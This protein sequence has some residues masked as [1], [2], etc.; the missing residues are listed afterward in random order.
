MGKVWWPVV[1]SKDASH[2]YVVA[3]G[4]LYL[5][6]DAGRSWQRIWSGSIGWEI[7]VLYTS[8]ARYLFICNQWNAYYST[9]DGVSWQPLNPPSGLYVPSISCVLATSIDDQHVTVFAGNDQAVVR[10]TDMGQTWQTVSKDAGGAGFGANY[11]YGSAS[12][13]RFVLAL[14]RASLSGSTWP[15]NMY[16]SFDTGSTWQKCNMTT[17]L[18]GSSNPTVMTPCR[19]VVHPTDPH[20]LYLTTRERVFGS[21]DCGDTWQELMNG[22]RPGDN[23]QG[24]VLDVADHRSLWLTK[25]DGLFASSDAGAS[26][27]KRD[28]SCTQHNGSTPW[29]LTPV[30]LN[31]LVQSSS[32]PDTWYYSSGTSFYVSKDHCATWS[33]VLEGDVSALWGHQWSVD[34]TRL[35]AEGP[36]GIS[37]STDGARSWSVLC[38]YSGTVCAVARS[39]AAPESLFATATTNKLLVSTDGGQSWSLFDTPAQFGIIIADPRNASTLYASDFIQSYIDTSDASGKTYKSVDAGR[40]WIQVFGGL[41]A[42][43]CMAMAVAPSDS[44]RVLWASRREVY[45]SKDAGLTWKLVLQLKQ[46]GITWTVAFSPSITNTMYVSTE[47]EGVLRTTDGGVTWAPA[48]AGM[49]VTKYWHLL[50]VESTSPYRLFVSTA[51]GVFESDD[52]A[53]SWIPVNSNAVGVSFKQLSCSPGFGGLP[54]GITTTG[55]WMQLKLRLQPPADVK[56]Q[57]QKNAVQLTWT[58][59]TAG[60]VVP[61]AYDIWR[62]TD[63]A[64]GS[65]VRIGR[66]PE[67]TTTYTDATTWGYK[68][69]YYKVGAWDG[70]ETP[71]QVLLSTAVN[72]ASLDDIP[73]VITLKSPTTN[74]WT[75][76]DASCSLSFSVTDIET[77]VASVTVDGSATGLS[78]YYGTYT[79][80]L[81]LEPG[82][83][84][85][86]IVAHDTAGNTTQL[87]VRI[88]YIRT[89]VAQVHPA[90][91]YV[92]AYISPGYRPVSV[93]TVR[94]RTFVPVRDLA[95][96][97]GA[98]VSWDA[99]ARRATITRGTTTVVLWIGKPTAMVN[100][101]RTPIDA[102]DSKVVPF[103][104]GGKT[105]MPVNFVASSFGATVSYDAKTKIVTITLKEG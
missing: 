7:Q 91:P 31:A 63:A 76:L 24:F 40:T 21:S 86:L 37:V 46:P 12:D 74:P 59:V 16:R 48:T 45:L 72:A 90:V 69:Y 50:A 9:D 100:D 85:V 38:D 4:G 62:S 3:D 10:S 27:I 83:R 11:L 104:E 73:P 54:M 92:S 67:G 56:A 35:C 28:V 34:G 95:E 84:Q 33:R 101:V 53:D 57:S 29:T 30:I 70:Q 82:W 98:Q 15:R 88:R 47:T 99:V 103:I 71:E 66:A 79:Q 55:I 81:T 49:S 58:S 51:Y 23:L 77:G 20:V 93:K 39:P 26:W 89:T 75:S 102:K 61:V 1:D 44:S 60:S 64:F 22:L 52:G 36:G 43:H 42:R 97:L 14:T 6:T 32:S 13:P 68:P 41:P 19:V 65:P 18:A 17:P 8:I 78:Q 105:Y 96:A 80:N 94:S 25:S 2:V 87:A 5:S